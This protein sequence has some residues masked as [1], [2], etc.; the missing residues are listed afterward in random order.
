[1]RP[2]AWGAATG[3]TVVGDE[4]E[5]QSREDEPADG[6]DGEEHIGVTAAGE[7]GGGPWSRDPWAGSDWA[8][9]PSRRRRFRWFARLAAAVAALMIAGIGVG[10]A[11]LGRHTTST[12]TAATSASGGS[13]ATST[14]Q[15][16]VDINTKLGFQ[17]GSA[18]GTGVVLSSAGE[19]L[20]NNHV[21]AGATS[22]S[23]TDVGNGRTYTATV[24][25]TDLTDD[26]AVLQLN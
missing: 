10:F 5:A 20:T 23:V 7:D 26:I 16:V 2:S 25:G 9:R 12:A 17:G 4:H 22:I 21:V 13:T 6:G 1:E 3:T 8:P 19:I 24:V 11:V 18:A 14:D 15:G